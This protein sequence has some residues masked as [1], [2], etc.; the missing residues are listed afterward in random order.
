MSIIHVLQEVKIYISS[1]HSWP[2]TVTSLRNASSIVGSYRSV[3]ICDTNC[4]VKL[5]FPTPFPSANLLHQ[6]SNDCRVPPLPNKAILYSLIPFGGLGFDRGCLI[7]AVFDKSLLRRFLSAHKFQGQFSS[8][9]PPRLTFDKQLTNPPHKQKLPS[10][11]VDDCDPI[12]YSKGKVRRRG[13]DGE[14]V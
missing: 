3:H 1:T 9:Q 10:Q 12:L 6:K 7:I 2:S 4:P 14:G 5:D 13:K 8:T 11:S